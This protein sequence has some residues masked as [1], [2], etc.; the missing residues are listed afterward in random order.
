M[1]PAEYGTHLARQATKPLTPEQI[2]AAARI[3]A[4]VEPELAAA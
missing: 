3:L 2:E 4:G 1:T